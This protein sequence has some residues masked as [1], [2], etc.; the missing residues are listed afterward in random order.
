MTTFSGSA[1]ITG[2]TSGIGRATA[3]LLHERGYRV[4]VTGRSP[5]SVAQAREELPADVLVIRADARRVSE[6]ADAIAEVG[7][8]FGHLTTLFINAGI[9]R[10][11]ALGTVDEATWD[12]IHDTNTK[13]S[14]FTLQQALPLLTDGASVIFTGGLGAT[15]PFGIAG[16]S[17]TAASRGALIAMVSSLALELAP[18]A[19]RVNAVSPGAIET[20]IWGKSA[21][22]AEAV[23]ARKAAIA[24]RTP[25]GRFG[26][27][28]E[29]AETVAFLASDGAA[30]LTGQNIVVAG[31]GG[32]G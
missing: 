12:E 28:R 17:A 6:T 8:R 25:L 14:Y 21:A 32:L 5:E 22:P 11:A 7:E 19:I 13:G 23:A 27:A 18:R 3:E 9:T 15:P 2:G 10:A 16:G 20:P 1:L 26:T 4:A 29:I 24:A 31:G 30:Y